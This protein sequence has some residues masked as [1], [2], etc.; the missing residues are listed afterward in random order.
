MDLAKQKAERTYS[1]EALLPNLKTA[2][3]GATP[4]GD[5]RQAFSVRGVFSHEPPLS[6]TS[7][8]QS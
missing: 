6:I 8:V 2:I 7:S 3:P 1:R 4:R 5:A